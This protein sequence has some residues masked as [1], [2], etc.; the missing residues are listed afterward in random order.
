[1]FQEEGGKPEKP[2]WFLASNQGGT[3]EKKKTLGEEIPS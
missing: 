2:D 3:Y 1:M